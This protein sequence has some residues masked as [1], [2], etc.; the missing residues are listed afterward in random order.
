[1]KGEPVAKEDGDCKIIR[2]DRAVRKTT[3]PGEDGSEEIIRR[4]Y[5]VELSDGSMRTFFDVSRATATEYRRIKED[6]F[7]E[8]E[9]RKILDNEP[10]STDPSVD[11]RRVISSINWEEEIAINEIRSELENLHGLCSSKENYSIDDPVDRIKRSIQLIHSYAGIFRLPKNL[12]LAEELRKL[13]PSGATFKK[14]D[15]LLS[16]MDRRDP[17][18]VVVF[19]Y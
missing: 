19:P 16:Y 4:S 18:N 8:T 14:T 12:E 2:F 13:R 15:F 7:T 3:L 11:C 6:G 17:G 9:I 5:T 1:M 10:F